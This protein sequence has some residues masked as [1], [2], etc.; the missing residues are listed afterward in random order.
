MENKVIGNELIIG[1]WVYHKPNL[2]PNENG[3]IIIITKLSFGP[4][5]VFEWGIDSKR[6]PYEMYMWCENDFFKT[7]NYIK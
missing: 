2:I 4:L 1:K 3:N 5:E 6:K 7:D